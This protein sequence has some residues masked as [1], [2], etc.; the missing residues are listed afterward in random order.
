[1]DALSLL[2][3]FLSIACAVGVVVLFFYAPIF[4]EKL[5]SLTG[6]SAEKTG[7]YVGVKSSSRRVWVIYNPVKSEKV[8]T[9]K[10]DCFEAARAAGFEDIYFVETLPDSPGDTQAHEAIA[11]GVSRIIA[12]GGDGT[13]RLVAGVIAESGEKVTFG[14]LPLGTGNLY[15][16]N[17]GIS[18]DDWEQ[19]LK[20]AFGNHSSLVDIGWLRATEEVVDSSDS[21]VS[22]VSPLHTGEHPFLVISG[23][24]FDSR[25]I[26]DTNPELKKRIG[27]GAYV[28]AGI[29]NSFIPPVQVKVSVDEGKEVYDMSIRSL[30]VANSGKLPGGMNLVPDAQPDDGILDICVMDFKHG[31]IG[32]LAVFGQVVLQNLGLHLPP[33]KGRQGFIRFKQAENLDCLIPDGYQIQVDGDPIGRYRRVR[34]RVQPR[35]FALACPAPQ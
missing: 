22:L 30:F 15:A 33:R 20:T 18:T 23:L 11:S 3:W 25:M 5:S 16:R 6:V 34:I 7:T 35:A 28:A 2:P 31:I 8:P 24:G 27:W 17:V 21:D 9:F 13:V 1:M 32:W 29:K 19:N 26:A 10:K 14:I 4:G 12:A